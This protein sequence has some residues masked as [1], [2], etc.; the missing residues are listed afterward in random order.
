MDTDHLWRQFRDS[1]DYLVW[2]YD[3]QRWLPS[4]AALQFDPEMSSSWTEHLSD[5][6]IGPDGILDRNKGYSLVGRW[7]VAAL[8]KLEFPVEHSP[9]GNR[10]IDCAHSSVYWPPDA[11]GEGKREPSKS[12]RKQL[13][14]DLA[15]QMTWVLGDIMTDAPEDG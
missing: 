3:N 9:C 12:L 2:D 13:R 7:Q 6:K 14:S 1:D 8:R 15:A 5:H 4:P 11:V 10:P